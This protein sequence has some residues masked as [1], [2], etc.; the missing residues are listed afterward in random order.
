MLK[1]KN[2]KCQSSVRNNIP[3]CKGKSFQ[4]SQFMEVSLIKS[5]RFSVWKLK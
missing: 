5:V 2:V 3:N 4:I 1:K